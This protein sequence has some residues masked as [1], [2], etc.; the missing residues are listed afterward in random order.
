MA[1]LLNQTITTALTNA[2][3]TAQQVQGQMGVESVTIQ[4]NF[5]YGSGGTTATTWVQT[6]LDG[7]LTWTDVANFAFTTSSLRAVAT[8]S[9]LTEFSIAMADRARMRSRTRAACSKSISSDA[10]CISLDRRLMTARDLPRRNCSASV[11]SS[12]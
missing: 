7:G 6:S 4:A 9:A 10:A 8:L 11:T 2:V 12:P 3:S 5:T 1:M